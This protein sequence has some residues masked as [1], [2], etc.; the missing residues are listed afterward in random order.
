MNW[1]TTM[2][3]N[4]PHLVLH[5]LNWEQLT[6]LFESRE[7]NIVL[8]EISLYTLHKDYLFTVIKFSK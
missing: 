3:A 2:L 6:F 7:C 8:K 4:H 1:S 5:R